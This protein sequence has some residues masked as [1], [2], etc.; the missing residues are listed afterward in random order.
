MKINW[1]G[2]NKV[3]MEQ[4]TGMKETGRRQSQKSRT[5]GLFTGETGIPKFGLIMAAQ[6]AGETFTRQGTVQDD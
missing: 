1:H 4:K 3:N 5:D 6:A 2:D